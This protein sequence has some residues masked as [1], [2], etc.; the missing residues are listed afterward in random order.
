MRRRVRAQ[1]IVDT[2]SG[3]SDL[4]SHADAADAFARMGISVPM[5]AEPPGYAGRTVGGFAA[6]GVGGEMR[7]G[8]GGSI[9]ACCGRPHSLPSLPASLTPSPAY[10]QSTTDT[11]N[12]SCSIHDYCTVNATNDE[13]INATDLA[14]QANASF[15]SVADPSKIVRDHPSCFLSH[16]A[17]CLV[18]D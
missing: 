16:P 15:A 13:L 7:K 6:L 9:V 18:S 10:A 1:P 8:P 5:G 11:K 12:S 2:F 14:H 17:S 3:D 4:N